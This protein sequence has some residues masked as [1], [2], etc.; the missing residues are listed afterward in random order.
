MPCTSFFVSFVLNVIVPD[1]N[2]LKESLILDK[3]KPFVTNFFF[4]HWNL[5][6]LYL[7]KYLALYVEKFVY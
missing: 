5:I 7:K 6:Y 1:Y 4:F 2:G 3:T